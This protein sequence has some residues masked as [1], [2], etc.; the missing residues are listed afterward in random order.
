MCSFQRYE[1]LVFSKEHMLLRLGNCI[2]DDNFSLGVG[3]ID[4]IKLKLLLSSTTG[5]KEPDLSDLE[6]FSLPKIGMFY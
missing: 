5:L 1:K 2:V 4:Y 3:S 6:Y